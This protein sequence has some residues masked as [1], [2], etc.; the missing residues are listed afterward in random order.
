MNSIQ[1]K[2][3]KAFPIIMF[4]IINIILITLVSILGYYY[5]TNNRQTNNQNL[6]KP[7]P[8]TTPSENVIIDNDLA[9]ELFRGNN[10]QTDTPTPTSTTTPSPT[11]SPSSS[12]SLTVTNTTITNTPQRQTQSPLLSITLTDQNKI[13]EIQTIHFPDE[14]KWTHIEKLVKSRA[15]S[16]GF[17]DKFS[18]YSQLKVT[19]CNT[20]LDRYRSFNWSDLEEM[21][22]VGILKKA[23]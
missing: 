19:Q 10:T 4:V 21:I 22:R 7:S 8:T 17:N 14:V 18:Y 15:Y 5:F 23:F 9:D 6:S 3:I 20:C 13:N 11:Q 1:Y 12:P 2:V 16:L